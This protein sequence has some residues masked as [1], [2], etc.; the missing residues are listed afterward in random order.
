MKWQALQLERVAQRPSQCNKVRTPGRKK[1]KERA[2]AGKE[3]CKCQDKNNQKCNF[4]MAGSRG[5]M[6]RNKCL[7]RIWKCKA[8]RR[9]LADG[10]CGMLF[11]KNDV[12]L[13]LT[14]QAIN[15]TE[16]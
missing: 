8:G 11:L 4:L 16:M 14:L 9:Q 12:L 1:S 3:Y 2:S 13:L 10:W 15:I 7:E 6:K 5:N